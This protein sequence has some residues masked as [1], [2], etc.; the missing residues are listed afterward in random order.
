MNVW[1]FWRR[2]PVKADGQI[3][4]VWVPSTPFHLTTFLI[5]RSLASM[6]MSSLMILRWS[7]LGP[8]L[9]FKYCIA[10]SARNCT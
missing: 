4:E 1:D 7:K 6:D 3:D 9:H 10:V 5:L 8:K 2:L